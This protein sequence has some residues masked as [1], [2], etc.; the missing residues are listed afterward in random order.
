MKY[1]VTG[2]AGFIGSHIVARLLQE[3]HEVI[4]MDNASSTSYDEPYW[5][6]DAKNYNWDVIDYKLVKFLSM[7][8]DAIF[9]LA[10]ETKIQETIE[11]PR[12]AL[13]TN[14]MGTFNVLQAARENN[15]KRVIYSST[16]AAYGDNPVPNLEDMKRDCMN[17]YSV[18]KTAGE[19]LCQMY[20]KLYGV[21][22]VIFR[23]FNVYGERQ[24]SRGQYAPVVGIFKRQYEN[25]EP[26][27]V[28]GDGSQTR[29]YVH[30]SDVVEAN[31]LASLSKDPKVIG[32]IFNIGTEETHSVL[33]LV[34]YIGGENAEIT[35]L[36]ERIG[37]I[38]H[39][40]S[41]CSKAHK[42]LQWTPQVNIKEWILS[43][44]KENTKR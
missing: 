24:P 44:E 29:D 8:V 37:E 28:V 2:G 27:T 1:L 5:N 31:I 17:P 9:H 41:D 10:A 6:Y 20:S 4:V 40:F 30:V 13:E 39:S 42:Y 21:E 32:E 35:H 36:P 15:I 3:G 33:D 26:M 11:N 19:E 7:G 34:E 23:Y 43:H 25:D 16:A 22:T 18:S 12:Q 14:I 38:K